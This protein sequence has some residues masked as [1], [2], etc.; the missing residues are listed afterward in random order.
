[1]NKNKMSK[2]VLITGSSSGIGE[3]CARIFASAG[4]NLILL[5]RRE[6]KLNNLSNELIEKYKIDIQ[7]IQADVRN[8]EVLLSKINNLDNNWKKIDVLINNAGLARGLEKFQNS[9]LSDWEEMIDTNIKGLLYVSKIIVPLMIE[10][11]KGLIINIGSIAGEVTY[12]S[13]SVYC[14]SKSAVKSISEGM[15][16]DL[17]NTGVKVCNIEPGMVET[18]FSIIRFHGDTERSE[19]VY[20]EMEPLLGTDIGEI[21][22]HVASLPQRVNIQNIIITPTSQANVY[23]NK[24]TAK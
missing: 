12:P 7:I 2:I 1:M 14:G 5:A 18:E 15:S 11:G 17:I 9:L 19:V 22:L 23:V 20:K 8:Y 24:K 3:G 16:L 6:E 21:A 4:Y 10:R 13:G